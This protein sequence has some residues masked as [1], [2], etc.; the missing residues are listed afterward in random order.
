M[1]SY[2]EMCLS[3]AVWILKHLFNY[4]FKVIVSLESVV[5]ISPTGEILQFDLLFLYQFLVSKPPN[6]FLK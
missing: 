2:V 6:S 5:N 1:V 3:F 4:D